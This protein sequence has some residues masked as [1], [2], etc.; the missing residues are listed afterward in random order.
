MGGVDVRAALV[1]VVIPTYNRSQLLRRALE[2]VLSQSHSNWEAI[3]I[4]DGS[5]DDT[6]EMVAS[7]FSGESRIRYFRQQNEGVSSARNRGL[8]LSRGEYIAFLDSDDFW[9]PWKLEL[10]LSCFKADPEI[11]MVWTNMTAVN[12]NGRIVA[13][14][15][16]EVMY[17]SRRLFRDEELFD[18]TYA[19]PK[20]SGFPGAAAP[21]L[22]T[23]VIWSQMVT[24][25]LVHTSTV[26]LCRDWAGKVGEF[27]AEYRP[28][29]ED[30]DFHFRTTRLGRVGFVD[31]P[32][33]LYQVGMPDALTERAN[34]VTA[35]KNFLRV[36]EPVI[37]N[38]RPLIKL[39]DAAIDETLAYGYR[40]YGTELLLHGQR[41]EARAVLARSL[42]RRWEMQAFLFYAL[43]WLPV[44]WTAALRKLWRLVRPAARRQSDRHPTSI[45]FKTAD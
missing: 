39:S 37:E 34:M 11:G 44:S 8:R 26:I 10:Q 29:G 25:S 17:R 12:G 19:L 20:P 43:A 2:G 4:D 9:A 27:K 13:E 22:K 30:F 36:I 6:G 45:Y 23:G 16:L 38:E 21:V 32:S 1:S 15:Y 35:A 40:W 18:R 5:T 24:G 3:V 14:R 7:R 31:V 33:I 42:R 28:L 41:E